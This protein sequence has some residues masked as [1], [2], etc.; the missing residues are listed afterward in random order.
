[1]ADSSIRNF[2]KGLRALERQVEF[3]LV[4]QTEC[5]G[6]TPA[7]CHLLLAVEEA[8]EASVG[9]LAAVL[10]LDASTL[11]RTVDG[12]VRTRTLERREDPDN[13]R[14]QLVRLSVSGRE[15]ADTINDL[16][17]RYYDGLLA[18]LP[19]GE[20]DMLM[21]ALPLFAKAMRAWRCSG[22]GGG[23]GGCCREPE[24]AER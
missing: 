15:K 11:S 24:A 13:R 8:G 18:S 5:C 17:D 1:M 21:A 16:C 3:A 20:K 9:D 22:R 2:R 4:A 12:L 7:Q 6:V 10:E 23:S 14:R 19:A